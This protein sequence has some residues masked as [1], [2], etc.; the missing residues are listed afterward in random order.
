MNSEK[1]I[2]CP[3]FANGV[4]TAVCQN[5]LALTETAGYMHDLFDEGLEVEEV[6]LAGV[7]FLGTLTDMGIMIR[8]RCKYE[9]H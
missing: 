3:F 5:H 8:P 7:G 9:A 2:I 1:P 6:I 4:C